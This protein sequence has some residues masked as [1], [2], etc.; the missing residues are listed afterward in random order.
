MAV[1]QLTKVCILALCVLSIGV[2][3]HACAPD[4]SGLAMS[5]GVI[6]S[7]EVL[8]PRQALAQTYYIRTDGGSPDQCTGLVDAPYPES[9]T[10]QPCAW[11]HPFYALP[12][13]GVPRLSG[14]DTLII[15][16]GSYMMGVDAPGDTYCDPFS[17]WDCYMSPIPSG[18]APDQPTRILGAGWAEGC[19]NPPELWGTQRSDLILNLSG[20]SNVEI[21]CLE[22][23]D[24]AGCVEF[25]SGGLACERD[26]Y[27]FG[28]W[29]AIGLYAED[30]AHITLR[31]LNIHGLGSNGVLAGRLADWTVEHVRIAGNG[32]AGWDG[33]IEG[34]DTN[35]GTLTFRHWTV[36]WNGC[37]ETY[38]GGDPTGCW[39][40]SA[41]GYGDGV[42][43]GTTGGHWIIEDSAFLH[44]TSDG[45]DLLYARETG[46]MIEIRR[47][48]AEGNAGDQIKSS[49]P[50]LLENVIAV[51]NCGF[52]DGKSFTFDV[53]NCRAGGSAVALSPRASNH[54]TI[55][56]S[57]LTGQG[58]CLVI[59]ECAEGA[60]CNGSESVLMRNTIFLG[61][62]EFGEAEDTTCLTWYDDNNLPVD[63]FDT[64]YAVIDA[65]KNIPDPCPAGSFCNM[66]P[67]LSNSSLD[68]FDAHLLAHSIARDNG[69]PVNAPADDFDGLARDNQPDIGA[70]EYGAAAT[71]QAAFSASPRLGLPPL[72]VH[73]TDESSGSVTQWWWNFGDGMTHTVRHPSHTY[74]TTG[75]YTVTLTVS[76]TSGSDTEIKPNYVIVGGVF[77]TYLPIITKG[78]S[79]FRGME[80]GE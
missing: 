46:S 76:D 27:P 24:H 22:V 39:A 38:P 18:P 14:G 49:G 32:W 8:K 41:G 43:T 17:A 71:V 42:G 10:G 4:Q 68:N 59:A 69:S 12:P 7:P 1:Q 33:D 21:A 51:S 6:A 63:P 20:S 45:L 34:D 19:L 57:T 9:G 58:D 70:Y 35:S 36:E 26:A 50:T 47:T 15:A 52:F 56:N 48:L 74:E 5:P 64:D 67:G 77:P 55:V 78:L 3:A 28:K 23:T 37:A 44:N 31:N 60:E 61:N 80:N 30:A 11:E 53:D 54:I 40:Q 65:V 62:P 72:Y 29:A 16:A 25:H 79:V 75:T 66:A 13:G 73:F 2:L